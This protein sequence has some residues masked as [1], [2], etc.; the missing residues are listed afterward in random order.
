MKKKSLG[1][2]LTLIIIAILFKVITSG[3]E[4][5]IEEAINISSVK[6]AR[7]I[8]EEKNS[9]GS[10]VFTY[11]SEGDGL[12]VS[13]VKKGI[14][15]YKEA[16]SASHGD[17]KV[18]LEKLGLLCGYLPKIKGTELPIYYGVVGDEVEAVKV[19]EKKRNIEKEAKIIDAD[20]ERI[21][22]I[23]M[24][25]FRGS[26]FD[27]VT[28]SREGKEIKRVTDDISPLYVEQKASKG[29]Q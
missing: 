27:I 20:G 13:A 28:L 24:E 6:S 17:I 25:G 21:W 2:I 10:I 29:Y 9:K 23:Y 12:H 22:L 14:G 19:V 7:I 5:T 16:Y 15:G 4:K 18:T 8:H 3:G 26:Q 1:V 11:I